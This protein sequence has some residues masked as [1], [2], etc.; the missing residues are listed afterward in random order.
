[1]QVKCVKCGAEVDML[2]TASPKGQPY[3]EVCAHEQGWRTNRECR[4]A[5]CLITG[6]SMDLS[7]EEQLADLEPFQRLEVLRKAGLAE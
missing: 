7:I 5:V 6:R 2:D 4:A 1:M 3:C